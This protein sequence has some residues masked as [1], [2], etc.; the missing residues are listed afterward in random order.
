MASGHNNIKVT[1]SVSGKFHAFHLAGQL[2]KRGY[3]DRIFTSYPWLAVK[4]SGLPR[5]KVSCLISKEILERLLYKIPYLSEKTA[6]ANY[7]ADFFDNQVAAR[8]KPCSIFVGAPRYSLNTI[9]KIRKSFPAKVIIERVSSHIQAYRNILLEEQE[10]LG[11]KS[12]FI[13]S[14]VMEKELQEYQEAD[15]I[16]V[17]STFARQTFLNK[18]FSEDKLINMPWGVDTSTFRPIPKRDNVFRII[19]VGMRIIKGIHYLLRAVDELGLKG[20]ELWLIGGSI[21]DGLKPFLKKYSKKFRYLGAI[22]QRQLYKYYSQGSLFVL[23]SLEDGFGM[24]LLEAMS[25]GLPVICSDS[26]GA[27]DVVRDTID[28]FIVPTRD[29]SA[30][31]EKIL[32]LYDNP[33]I[34]QRMGDSA[35]ENVTRNFTWDNYGD[36]VSNTYLNLLK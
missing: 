1:I 23:F 20:L 13:P 35:R 11:I 18:N 29:V 16:A 2:E 14:R 30:L 6:V 3:L 36:K 22:P 7:I 12:N 27:K 5:R 26:V 25:C 15:Y 8:I 24:S 9:R 31:K 34:R 33:H 19:S 17:P 10:R 32:Y 28:G 4:D 21:D